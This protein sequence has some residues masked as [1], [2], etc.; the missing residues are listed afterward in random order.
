[1]NFRNIGSASAKI[2]R[3]EFAIQDSATKRD[4][5]LNQSWDTC[6]LPGQHVDMSMIFAHQDSLGEECPKCSKICVGDQEQELK[7]FVH[8][9]TNYEPC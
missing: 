1:M 3:G 7:W 9:S 4:I 8:D 6:F 5:D 2:E